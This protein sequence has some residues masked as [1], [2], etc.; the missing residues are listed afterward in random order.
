MRVQIEKYIIFISRVLNGKRNWMTSNN[1]QMNANPEICRM[2][3][4]LGHS[5][6]F[7]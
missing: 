7:Y 2:S 1:P 5:Q 6:L 4:V 3:Q